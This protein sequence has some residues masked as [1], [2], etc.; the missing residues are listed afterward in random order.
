MENRQILD[1]WKEIAVYLNRS[2]RCC[3]LWTKELGLPV[4]RLK[5]SPRARVYAYKDEIDRWRAEIQHSDG[6]K[7]V[8]DRYGSA[9]LF[10]GILH[11]VPSGETRVSRRLA[12]RRRL[13]Y[14]ATGAAV[15]LLAAAALVLRPWRRSTVSLTAGDSVVVLPCKVYGA[16]DSEYLTEAIPGSLS[17]LLGNVERLDIRAPI[18]NT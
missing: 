4:H 13:I 9:A 15:I 11:K 17:T 1:S 14:I 16:E 7:K 10:D 6:A 18:T 3:R 8:D 12:A 2:E 5:E